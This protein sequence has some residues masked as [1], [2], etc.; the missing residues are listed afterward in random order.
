MITLFFTVW[1]I[2]SLSNFIF[3]YSTVITELFSLQLFLVPAILL[4]FL[5][6]YLI[7]KSHKAVFS[8]KIIQPKLVDS[9]VYSRVRHPMYFGILLFCLGFF[10]IIPSLLSF[11]VWLAFFILYDRMATYEEKQL[12]RKLGEEY[13]AYQKR[14]P[15]WFPIPKI[16][17]PGKIS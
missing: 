13:T 7:A 3:E 14:V 17:N 10:F 6:A 2:D 9:G 8:E 1:T 11:G 15:K 12:I 4:L 16:G 5:G